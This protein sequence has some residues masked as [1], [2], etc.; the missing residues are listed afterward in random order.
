MTYSASR[1]RIASLATQGLA[2]LALCA[3]SIC[4]QARGCD[5]SNPG[6]D[7]YT[8]TPEAAL[9]RYSDIPAA[10][11]AKLLD[12]MRRH[13]YDDQVSIDAKGITGKRRYE[14]RL[15]G[16][17]FGQSRI[18]GEVDRSGLRAP[19]SALAY[20]VDGYTILVP[21]ICGNISRARRIEDDE[22]L[23]ASPRAGIPSSGGGGGFIPL[24]PLAAVPADPAIGALAPSAPSTEIAFA[25]PAAGAAP[26]TF[27]A[28]AI[29]AFSGSPSVIFY[30]GFTI[31]IAT[32]PIGSG[33]AILP[34]VPEPASWALMALG[35]LMLAAW[36][37]KAKRAEAPASPSR[38]GR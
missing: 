17:H 2:T 12:N 25:P 4:A 38:A 20:T 5:W 16:M 13:A 37:K 36:A 8:G 29:P 28:G 9:A 32:A 19:Q 34:S 1:H 27:Q 10:T 24:A 7:R 22:P 26:T 35:S 31:P 21:A 14:P 23:D 11:R 6:A 30:P 33:G 15:W 18:C 3:A